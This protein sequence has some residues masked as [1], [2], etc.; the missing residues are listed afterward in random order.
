MFTL[1][2]V[3]IYAVKQLQNVIAD[4]QSLLEF[5]K[6]FRRELCGEERSTPVVTE[7]LIQN[8]ELI[9]TQK[10][11]GSNLWHNWPEEN[12][13]ISN[14][15]FEEISKRYQ[16]HCI[17]SCS[18]SSQHCYKILVHA[19][20]SNHT[21]CLKMDITQ[22]PVDDLEP[23]TNTDDEDEKNDENEEEEEK[24]EE[25]DDEERRKAE[26]TRRQSILVDNETDDTEDYG[27]EEIAADELEDD[28]DPNDMD[29]ESD[30]DVNGFF[31]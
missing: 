6:L 30:Q 29:I 13:I 24:E 11:A 8:T 19:T 5:H 4:P 20:S 9:E 26:L 17:D 14:E 1:D 12:R 31:C 22:L 10:E 16:R 15:T 27:C 3:I 7:S 2:K 21:G 25:E 23:L 18:K 28:I